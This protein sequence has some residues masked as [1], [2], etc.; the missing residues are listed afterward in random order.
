M[1][2]Q[3]LPEHRGQIVFTNTVVTVCD[4]GI[5]D[6][7]EHERWSEPELWPLSVVVVVVVVVEFL[8]LPLL[9]CSRRSSE[10]G[11]SDGNT[12]ASRTHS[13]IQPFSLFYYRDR[14]GGG[15]GI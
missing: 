8:L 9:A 3:L 4:G 5:L 6:L 10:S 2:E 15:G 7:G 11:H 12:P 14:V 1:W 13:L